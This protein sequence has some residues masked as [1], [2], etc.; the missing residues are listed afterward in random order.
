MESNHDVNMYMYSIID[1]IIRM[2]SF[3]NFYF[4]IEIIN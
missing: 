3:D 1:R 2:C 4:K